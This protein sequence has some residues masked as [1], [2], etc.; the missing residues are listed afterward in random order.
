MSNLSKKESQ[1]VPR[2][3]DDDESNEVAA[4]FCDTNIVILADDDKQDADLKHVLIPKSERR[5]RC[6]EF[7]RLCLVNIFKSFDR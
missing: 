6:C 4:T 1:D 3:A 5:W 7:K 2:T